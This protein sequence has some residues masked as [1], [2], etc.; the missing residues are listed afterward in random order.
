M[1]LPSFD[2]PGLLTDFDSIPHQREAWS[3]YVSFLFDQAVARV[4]SLVGPGHSPYYNPAK[5]DTDAG[6]ASNTIR[7]KGFPLIIKSK[8]PGNLKAAYKEADTLLAGGERPQDEYLEWFIEKN[9]AEKITRITFTCEAPEYWEALAHGYPS[10]YHGPKIAG[11]SGDRNKVLELY[12]QYVS[13]SVQMA[14]LFPG[15]QYDRLNKYNS[16]QG[17]MHLQQRNNSL[18]A[19]IFIGGDATVLR[20]KHGQVLTD[21]VEL[22]ECAGFGEALRASDP[23][24]GS[25]VNALARQGF[26][27]TLLNPVGLYMEKPDTAGWQTPDGTDP[28]T[29]WTRLR[30]TEEATVRGVFEVPAAKGYTVGDIKIGGLP[31]Q[32]GGQIAENITVK[33]TGIA[34]RVGSKLNPPKACAGPGAVA[35]PGG[36]V[37]RATKAVQ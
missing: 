28:A 33:L 25:E 15:G 10:D 12:R 37:T 14:D 24:I 8:H 19:E 22:I 13:Q 5:V 16:T 4:E 21:A 35:A 1:L 26:A 31:I 9:A 34:C 7:W 3:A 23:H 30:G 11:V 2:P 36:L 20:Q 27:I 6:F 18:G 32:F 17:A 29:F